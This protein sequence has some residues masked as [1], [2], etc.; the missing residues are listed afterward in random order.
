MGNV[1][2]KLC[3]FTGLCPC[4]L[5]CKQSRHRS[6]LVGHCNHASCRLG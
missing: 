6:A 3:R 5:R 2:A 1:D 4:C